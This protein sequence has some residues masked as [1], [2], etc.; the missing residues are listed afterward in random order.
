MNIAAGGRTEQ[1]ALA[2]SVDVISFNQ[3]IQGR[4]GGL[5]GL[6]FPLAFDN[7]QRPYVW[8]EQKIIQ[9][10]EDL[11]AFCS[12]QKQSGQQ[13]YYFGSILLHNN[14]D[15]EKLY[16][17]DGQQRLTTLCVLYAV[18]CE[19]LPAGV[20]FDYRSTISVKNIQS[21]QKVILKS[22]P[23]EFD[24]SM[25][26]NLLFTVITVDRED[27]AFTFFD[28][29]NNR[30][31]ALNATDLLKA[32]HLRAVQSDDVVLSEQ[33]QGHCASRWESV[34]VQGEQG[35][36]SKANDFAPELFHYYLWRARNWCGRDVKEQEG[37]EDVLESFQHQSVSS[38]LGN[39]TLYP[40]GSNQW[41][42]E[43]TL[44]GNNEYHLQLR[45]LQMSQSAANLPLALRQPIP[46][47]VGFFLYAEKYA[48]LL[49]QILHEDTTDPEYLAL[50]EFYEPV[51][52]KHLSVYLQSLFRL[53]LLVYVD[54]LGSKGLLRF[55]LWLDHRLG[56]LRLNQADIR[57]ETPLKFLRD[58]KRNLLDVIAFAYRPEEVVTF[59]KAKDEGDIYA[60]NDGWKSEIESGSKVQ[61]RY[62]RAV[63]RY[64]GKLP[65]LKDKQNVIDDWVDQ[66]GLSSRKEP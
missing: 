26:D 55:S 39:V 50:R 60:K 16:V 8:S 22:I 9:L 61:G 7:Y 45:S 4:N 18:L 28:T 36:L 19:H 32:F 15:A 12:Q 21:A 62:T 53:A 29:Q 49:N 64:Y 6:E 2:V 66:K 44:Q 25:F 20:E 63:A 13:D 34:Q 59:L 38:E 54:R 40:G 3:L 33:L 27:L 52:R 51:I 10:I 23:A 37:S 14:S 5:T 43:L 17:I 42:T 65:S 35:K 1:A 31:V 41:A 11:K 30:G 56:A 58:S 48:A 57:R 24:R 47:G 46:Q